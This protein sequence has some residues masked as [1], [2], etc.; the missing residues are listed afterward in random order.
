[1]SH[2]LRLTPAP[3]SPFDARLFVT[4]WLRRWGYRHLIPAAALL[5]SELA[6]NA[7]VHGQG[8]FSVRVANTGNGVR[9]AVR[10]P[11]P[12]LPEVRRPEE[13]DTHGRGLRIVDAVSSRW[14]VDAAA[15]E[16]KEVWFELRM[17]DPGTRL[18]EGGTST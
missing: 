3:S 14:G 5:T 12:Q 6:T 17:T 18:L 1:M 13:V 9:V 2:D 4:Q 16:G 8:P 10:D 15:D 7:V 11:S